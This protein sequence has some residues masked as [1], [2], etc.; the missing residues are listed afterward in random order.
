M[1]VLRL[2]ASRR[3]KCVRRLACWWSTPA[4]RLERHT[5]ISTARWVWMRVQAFVWSSCMHFSGVWLLGV[6][7]P[8]RR[9]HAGYTL[10]SC[11]LENS[12]SMP[13]LL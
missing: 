2:A 6:W 7:L 11:T 5:A 12:C 1:W 3:Q 13:L 9:S 10:A 4:A 8:G